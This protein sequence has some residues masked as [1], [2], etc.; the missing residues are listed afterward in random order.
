MPSLPVRSGNLSRVTQRPPRSPAHNRA[1]N[2]SPHAPWRARLHEIIFEA[3]TRAGK[4]FDV[5]L[6]I[7]ILAS[8]AIVVVS[9]LPAAR[10]EPWNDIFLTLEWIFTALFT[11]EYILRLIVVR[12]PLRYARSFFGVIDLLAILPAF[13]GLLIPG[14]ERLLVVR[15]LRLLR[16][17][18]VFKLARYLSEATALRRAL[19]LSR[20]KIAVFLATVLIVVLIAS[21][22]MHI[23]EGNA[24]NTAFDSMPSAMYWAIITM[25]TVGYGDITPATSLGKLVTAI[26]VLVGYSLII[27][28]T[29]ILSAEMASAVRREPTTRA[30]PSCMAEGH[31]ANAIYCNRC[32]QLLDPEH[33][34][35][36][37]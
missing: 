8:V 4:V 28:P 15:T 34:P 25:T 1:T 12:R 26:L 29:G 18:R 32:G 10:A 5:A 36:A 37:S 27:I 13:L 31:D 20:H 23:V 3:D 19:I 33:T 21:A 16:V 30:C 9:T 11:A 35:A 24:G 17:F 14:G 7:A 6:I 2:G 22:I